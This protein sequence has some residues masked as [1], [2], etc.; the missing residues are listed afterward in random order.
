MPGRSA[1]S[2]KYV[3]PA[4][5]GDTD[6]TWNGR[7]RASGMCRPSPFSRDLPTSR[8]S[9]SDCAFDEGLFQLDTISSGVRHSGDQ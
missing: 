2:P 6:T 3:S 9:V 7:T 8:L 1:R 4:R 5:N